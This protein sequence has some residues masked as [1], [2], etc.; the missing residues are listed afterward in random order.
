LSF[1]YINLGNTANF[2]DEVRIAAGVLAFSQC[3]EIIIEPNI[4][5]YEVAAKSGNKVANNEVS[6]FRLI[7]NC[8]PR[9]LADIALGYPANNLKSLTIPNNISSNEDID[10]T[11]PLKIWRRNYVLALKVAALALEGGRMEIL[12]EKL[13]D[14][15][16]STY[17]FIAP[18]TILA[19]CYFSPNS[20][21]RGL[22]KKIKSSNRELAIEGIKNATWDLTLIHEWIKN[23]RNQSKKNTINIL[24][25]LDKKLHTIARNIFVFMDNEELI[26]TY[27]CEIFERQWG[28]NPNSHLYSKI[29]QYYSD[30][31]NSDRLANRVHDQPTIDDLILIGEHEIRKWRPRKCS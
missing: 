10:F 14:W 17:L 1:L 20:P 24:G 11:V 16:Y 29:T 7:D 8:N 12:T 5:L 26:D 2:T 19:L 13:F 18:S 22:F 3:C 31:E 9:I 6:K 4:A 21:K 23:V 15:M 27:R 30:S 28:I 25:S